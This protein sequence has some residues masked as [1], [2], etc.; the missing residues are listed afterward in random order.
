[1]DVGIIR[2]SNQGEMSKECVI[3]LRFSFNL[4]SLHY[5][6]RLAIASSFT[7]EIKICKICY[8]GISYVCIY[9]SLGKILA[10]IILKSIIVDIVV[11]RIRNVGPTQSV[12]K[13]K[14]GRGRIV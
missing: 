3:Q 11:L 4:Y 14:G 5:F 8:G 12:E 13:L 2:L 7:Y 10:C 1:M 9:A 6:E